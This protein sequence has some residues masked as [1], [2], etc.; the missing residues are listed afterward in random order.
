[1]TPEVRPIP[2]WSDKE[3]DAAIPGTIEHLNARRVLAYPTE[4][5]YGFGGAVDHGRGERV[6]CCAHAPVVFAGLGQRRAP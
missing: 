6:L 4:T 2:F 5:V 1:M 3:I